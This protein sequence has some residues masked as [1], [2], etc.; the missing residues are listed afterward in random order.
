MK[1]SSTHILFFLWISAGLATSHSWW[2]NPNSVW[3]ISQDG[4]WHAKKNPQQLQQMHSQEHSHQPHHSLVWQLHRTGGGSAVGGE[5]IPNHH[6]NI[7]R[8]HN[9]IKDSS[10]PQHNLFTLSPPRRCYR[11]ATGRTTWLK[12]SFYPE[13]I[14]GLVNDTQPLPLPALWLRGARIHPALE[15]NT[16]THS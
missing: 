8:G 4:I 2:G 15:I 5:S 7:R 14:I 9:I 11:S 1:F 6:Y 10:H 16:H 3:C 12:S 13:A